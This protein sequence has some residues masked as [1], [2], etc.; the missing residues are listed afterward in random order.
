MRIRDITEGVGRITKQNQTVDVGPDEVR[1][2]AAKFG[3]T[4]DK[5]GKP[6]TLSKKVKGS[7]TNVLFNLG[8]AE[9]V[10]YNK[11]IL[12]EAAIYE[13]FLDS[14]KQFLGNK[15]NQTAADIKGA[16][17]DLKSAGI[18]IK[19]IVQ[20]PDYL[21]KVNAQL[22]KSSQGL[23]KQINQLAGQNKI[24]AG[25]WN[26]IK[27][28]VSN[29][30]STAGWKGFLS[31]LGIYGF[32]KFIVVN[33]ASIKDTI[34][35]TIIDKITDLSNIIPNATMGGFLQVF[36]TL[37]AVKEYFFDVLSSIKTKLNFKPLGLA[38]GYKLQLERDR[39][40]LVLHIKDTATGKRTEVR[41]KPGYE[42]DYDPNDSLHIL[43]DKVGKSANISDLMNGEVVGINPK[44]PDADRAKAATD[45]AYNETYTRDQLPQIKNSQ[46]KNIKHTLETVDIDTIIPVQQERIIENF[47]RQVDNI[48]AGKY[49]PIIV[50]SNNKIVN[51]HHRYTALQML[52][53]KEVQVARLP[54]T[55]E[56]ILENFA[57]GKKK[58]K[59][60]P[61][62]VKRSGASCNGSVTALRK[63]AKNASGEKAKMYHWCANM[64]SGKKK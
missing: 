53:Y 47:K 43:L 11:D 46:L 2:Q 58:G 51:G 19:D 57:D 12:T 27:E 9:G 31:R 50:D 37:T 60:R 44:H 21:T 63:R 48:V 20:D 61:G 35:D 25:L 1:K 59:S 36:S 38:E 30:L 10:Y 5:D 56:Q 8:L 54:W 3:N 7:K 41:G 23:I 29:F 24:I 64:K 15:I 39:E 34:V 45:K 4:V 26:R 13:G 55:L 28:I 52:E 49:N 14:A 6:P 16:V 40:M 42:T 22:Y 32:L 62:R 18:L 17:V 33:T